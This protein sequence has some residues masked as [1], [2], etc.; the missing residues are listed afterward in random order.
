MLETASDRL[1]RAAG[2]ISARR[3]SSRRARLATI[4]AAGEARVPFTTG[5]LIGIGE[6]RAERIEAL[7]AIRELHERHGH[8]QEVIVQNFRAKPGTRMADAPGAV[9]RRAAVDGGR[10]PHRARPAHA[11]PGA[12]EPQLRR[13]PAP[14][15]R[16]DRR[17]GRRLAGHD[18]PRQPRGAVAR[19]RAA[20][21]GDA[22]RRARARAAAR[23]LSGVPR[24]SDVGRPGACVPT[25]LEPRRRAKVSPG[26]DRWAAGRRP[27]PDPRSSRVTRSPVRAARDA[28]SG[29]GGARAA[30][31]RRAGEEA[32]PGLRRRRRAA[33]RGQRRQGHLRRHAER[34]LHERLLLPLRLLR[35]LQGQARREPA[36]QALPRAGRRDRAPRARRPG[37]AARSRSASRAASTPPSPATPTSRSAR[38]SRR[39]CPASTSTRS[40]RSRSGRAR[41]RSASGSTPYLERLRDAGLASLPGTAA[42]ILDDEVRAVICPDKVTT[43]AVARGARRR[44]PRRPALDDD[45]HVR[46]RR[47][48]SV[49]GR[50]T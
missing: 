45:D 39:P 23:R 10:R 5:I 26:E 25:A 19:D 43:G 35:L 20:A 6:T 47:D 24:P 22:S 21:R 41:R 30:A 17:L 28:S 34:Q 18:R 46:P 36:R 4:D 16:R 37:S 27:C 8:V 15:R 11:R 50:A 3:T 48:A 33:P 49:R 9:A 14:A 44:A 1:S 13:V 38:R 32:R 42:E 7:L 2:R 31:S 29:R 40:R 12:A